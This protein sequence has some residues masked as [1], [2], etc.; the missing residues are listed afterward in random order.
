MRAAIKTSFAVTLLFIILIAISGC[1]DA[2]LK[3]KADL[4]KRINEKL[5][6]NAQ[7]VAEST[8][9]FPMTFKAPVDGVVY[10][11]GNG[12]ISLTIS[13]AADDIIKLNQW[14]SGAPMT[15]VTINEE[16]VYDNPVARWGDNRFYF[17]PETAHRTATP[18]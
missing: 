7:L 1:S 13:I 11:I 4:T 17:I 15:V 14:L 6:P 5:P 16:A 8:T 2:Q 9:S 18:D 10:Y 3:A 12:N